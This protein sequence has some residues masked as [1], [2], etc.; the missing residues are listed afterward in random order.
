MPGGRHTCSVDPDGLRGVPFL[1]SDKKDN[2]PEASLSNRLSFT[3]T[4]FLRK[5]GNWGIL[6]RKHKC[7]A[8]YIDAGIGPIE[9]QPPWHTAATFCTVATK[10][11]RYFMEHRI[12][13]PNEGILLSCMTPDEWRVNLRVPA[14]KEQS[15]YSV[16]LTMD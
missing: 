11:F 2:E 14:V 15:A 10:I 5:L 16:L 4:T 6:L 8:V 12:L 13:I 1:V 7:R 3:D 9:C